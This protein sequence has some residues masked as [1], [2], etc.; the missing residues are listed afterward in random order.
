MKKVFVLLILLFGFAALS[1]CGGSDTQTPMPN[2]TPTPNPTPNPPPTP[3]PDASVVTLTF[4]ASSSDDYTLESVD[5]NG[6]ATSENDPAINLVVGQRYRIINEQLVAHP[7]AFSGSDTY[8][9]SDLLLTDDGTGSFASNVGV[10]YVKN[11]DGF[12]FTLTAELKLRLKSYLCTR[13][14][15]MFGV[16]TVSGV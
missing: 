5:A 6:V 10:N 7:F 2:P 8:S 14:P 9:V 11:V 13:H 12:T 4:S 15:N 3:T 1:S 16:V